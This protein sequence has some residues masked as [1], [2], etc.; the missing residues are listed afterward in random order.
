MLGG[1]MGR[2]RKESTVETRVRGPGRKS[3]GEG[4]AGREGMNQPRGK[5][6]PSQTFA[7]PGA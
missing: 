4:G 6:N 7:D 2:H 1:G 5:Y 3:R